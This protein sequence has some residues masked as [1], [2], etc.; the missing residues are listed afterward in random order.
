M[1]KT[2]K[3]WDAATGQC[4]STFDTGQTL[5]YLQFDELTSN[6]LR[7]DVGTLDLR[8]AA[9]ATVGVASSSLASSSQLT[10]YGLSGD[11]TWIVYKGHNL[12][13][14]PSEYRPTSSAVSGT[15]VV[16]GCSSGRVLIFMFAEGNPVSKW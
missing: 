6:Y 10:G 14:L 8:P 15:T 9:H 4:V 1:D 13:W 12:I 2:V 16:I 11:G 7:T 5:R 3:I